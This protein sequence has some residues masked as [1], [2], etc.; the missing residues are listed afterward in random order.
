MPQTSS[1]RGEDEV[2]QDETFEKEQGRLETGRHAFRSH[3]S[4]HSGGV[5]QP[6]SPVAADHRRPPSDARPST[7]GSD[8]RRRGTKVRF[9]KDVNERPSTLLGG[10]P[11]KFSSTPKSVVPDKHD[12]KAEAIV[13]SPL[14]GGT[15][16]PALPTRSQS[17]SRNRGY[18]LRS[19]L[20]QRNLR[21][22]FRDDGVVIEMEPSQSSSRTSSDH[23]S[24]PKG[25]KDQSHVKVSEVP[26][27]EESYS[28]GS[29]GGS[30]P[31][32]VVPSRP[33]SSLPRLKSTGLLKGLERW[34]QKVKARIGKIHEIP[35]S[36][37]GRHIYLDFADY[38]EPV[39]ERTGMPYVSN[40][41][42]S[43]RYSLL[44]FFPRQ[45]FAQFA[46]L[47]NF[48]FLC[49]SILQMIPGL[50]TTG[51]YTT[52]VP[53]LIFVGISMGKEGYDDVRR[54]RLDKE[55][56][57]RNVLVLDR[58]Q[59]SC[60]PASRIN[61]P[62]TP[63][64]MQ[65]QL[66]RVRKWQDIKVGDVLLLLRNAQVP[67]DLV[68]LRAQSSDGIAYV[69]TMALDGETNLKTKQPLSCL[70]QLCET[71]DSVIK[72]N[73][74]FAVEDPNIDLYR[75]EGRVSIGG[76]TLSL[77]NNE[78]CYR[79]SI[80]RNTQNAVGL[81]IYTGEECKIRMNAN[82]NPR[83]KAPALQTVVNK[84]V[85]IIVFIVLTLA[86]FNSAAYE[87]W[88]KTTEQRS[89]YL[90]NAKVAFGPI[91][92]SFIIM[93]NTMIPLSLYVNLEIV[94]LAQ[95]YFMNDIDMY[96][97]A[98]NTPMEARTSTINEELGQVSYIFS[99]K[100]G[101]LTDNC[102]LFRKM[103]VAGTAWLHD[104]DLLTAANS[105][106]TKERL[107]HKKRSIKGKAVT[108]RKSIT[109][110]SAPAG[111][112]TTAT[113]KTSGNAPALGIGR[114]S[115]ASAQ[116][117]PSA[118]PY[119]SL[120][121]GRTEEMLEYIQRKP[122]TMFA[123]KVRLFVLSMALCHTCTPE[124]DENGNITFQAA[125][126]DEL[127]L[128]TAAQELEYVVINRQ[129]NAIVV[130]VFSSWSGGEPVYETFEVLDVIEFSSARKRMSVIVRMPD[131]RICIFCKG[132]D[133]A[134]TKLLR[135]SEL[136]STVVSNIG[137]LN[138]Q[139]KN[140]EAQEVLR[141]RSEQLSRR[142]SSVRVSFNTGP[143][144][145]AGPEG[146][147]IS[148]GRKDSFR[149]SIDRWLED[150]ETDVD[151]TYTR[152][153]VELYSPRPSGQLRSRMST[154]RTSIPEICD[155]PESLET[156]DWDGLVDEA[157]VGDERL[158]F[159]RCFQHINDFATEGLRTLLFGYR[160]ISQDEYDV[161]KKAYV[162]A[163]TSLTD[164]QAMIEQTADLIE[165]QLELVGAT[166]IEDK[167]QKGV[168]DAIDRLRRAKI[169]LWML[170]GDKRE[171]ATNIGH[172]C[173]MVKDY[174][175]VL[176]LDR[177]AG[178]VG[179]QI[180]AALI[181]LR[182]SD[183]AHSVMIVDGHTLALIESQ[184]SMKELFA[185]LAVSADSVICCRASPSQKASLVKM[186]RMRDKGTITLAVGDGAND[187]AMIQEA[188]V[189]IGITG[190]EGLQA[191]RSSDYSIAQFRFLLKLLL[192]HGRWNYIRIC[193][194]TL[195][196]FWKEMLFYL[197][198]ASYQRQNGY[199]GTSLY[200]PW[201]LSMF[202]TLFTG[203]PVIFMG[204]FEKDLAASTLLA[205]PELYNKGQHNGGFRIRIYLWWA[206]MAASESMIIFYTMYGIYGEALFTKDNG[207]YAMGALTF[208]S[209]VTVISLKLQ[210]LELHN[211]S[212]AAFIA[213]F[214]S[215]GGWYAWNLLLS[216]IYTNNTIYNVKDGLLERFG[217]NLL[218]W[219]T[220]GL[221]VCS[222]ALFEIGISSI[223]FVVRPSDVDVFQAYEQDREVRKRFEEAAA[224]LLQQGWDRGTKKSSVE[225][226]REAAV[227]AERETQVL[228]LLSRPRTMG[229]EQ[230]GAGEVRRRRSGPTSSAEGEEWA[231]MMSDDKEEP[232][233][234]KS[235]DASELFSQGF[236]KVRKGPDL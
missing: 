19:S 129:P 101:T 53:L 25:G 180:A 110:S 50:S 220:L 2:D 167:L 115:S 131:L 55:E 188:H 198:Q 229:R 196:T 127:A 214:L 228:D 36:V 69:E 21:S 82:K 218:W 7:S 44:N 173:R 43:S 223:R 52:I 210:V 199:T 176:I 31:P 15:N 84:V 54:Y 41:I 18:S 65:S 16:L 135:L 111:Y 164:R 45:L 114:R 102:M 221:V 182:E 59:F 153:S 75:F 6:I 118:R 212:I 148:L 139:R 175:T 17:R 12:A 168:P 70:S 143:S 121:S 234:R 172:S 183:A 217:Q 204:V 20:F 51:T 156:D 190:K 178:P 224:D 119:E 219:L 171:T 24:M 215:V 35:A 207:L 80:L 5:S 71:P 211:K 231:G 72:C 56:N 177:E 29:A 227:E 184:T 166:A 4:A 112:P 92:T 14:S 105:V 13:A 202:N 85:V 66:W 23:N 200:E 28:S 78:I 103:S 76:E 88:S 81:V 203:L 58:R 163:A 206:F 86:I 157:L 93:F 9:S 108:R 68:L 138:S 117:R 149:H 134:L 33:V 193:K 141:R 213:V 191:A 64:A 186:I 37:D 46:K 87:I 130:K 77:T 155:S 38:G 225:L 230:T 3:E 197:T 170:T 32:S 159:E 11:P 205:A 158:V 22:Q 89:W 208:T 99:D 209:C 30:T 140:L 126:P 216:S 109:S 128:V 174:S 113:I 222:V 232:A 189:G 95:M 39:D 62:D 34:V 235:A 42:R 63:L 150:R 132:A 151:M 124:K 154:N 147:R 97:E 90:E 98:S 136:A 161:W 60:H 40:F 91:L 187:I 74:H 47:A 61:A 144:T 83:I 100:T 195:G 152:A 233:R 226:A 104:S 146:G 122:H 1:K 160:H 48:Y 96:D 181:T 165:T 123:R 67:A 49:V 179:E 201:S 137:R 10:Q 57:N 236:G 116:W 106:S 185:D 26:S 27:S 133:S 94:K 162:D 145:P 79:G 169:K 194:Y 73:A 120:H 8:E 142:G 125:S 192:V 107:I